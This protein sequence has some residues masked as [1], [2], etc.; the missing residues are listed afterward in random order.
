MNK[1]LDKPEAEEENWDSRNH[2]QTFIL[3]LATVFGVYLCYQIAVPFL[4]VLAWAMTLAILFTPMQRWLESKL[5]YPSLSA[6]LSVLL[7]GL[8]VVVPIIFVGEQLVLQTLRGTELIESKVT[9]G[10]WRHT[11]ESQPQMAFILSKVEHYV[12]LPGALKT[13][14]TWLGA[15]VGV[16]VKGSVFQVLGLSL[17]FYMLFFF[18]RDRRLILKSITLFSPLTIVEMG[19]LFRRIGDAVHATI[20]GTFAVAA[21]QGFLGG[22]MFWWLDLPAPQLWGLVMGLL[23]IIPMLG[24]FVIW[25][26]AAIFL[27]L[28]GNWASA[29]IL[30]MW[31]ML[32][33]GT[34]DNLLRPILLGSRL[35]LHTVLIFLSVVGG[36]VFYG[37]VGLI[38]GP[39][40]LVIT[41]TLLEIWSNRNLGNAKETITLD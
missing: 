39:V 3:I 21:V 40:T 1:K 12:D 4:S 5:N 15:T 27:M 25:L 31:G 26:P 32:V 23:A 36:L 38:L 18:L 41:I 10:E 11:L 29:I 28:E 33:V 24:A 20:Y 22:L 8:I 13:F 17:V 6:L 30:T 37:P 16:V 14:T 2:I 7:I 35:K 34:V 19:I 9:S